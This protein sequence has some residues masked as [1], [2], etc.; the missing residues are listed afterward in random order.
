MSTNDKHGDPLR[1]PAVDYDRSD[2]SARGILLFL[3][4]LLVAG[5]FIELVLWGMFRFLSH[6]TLF[7]QGNPSPM[8]QVQRHAMP[9]KAPGAGLQNTG[10]VNTGVF[11]T[12][13]LQTNDDADMGK[14]L[15]QEKKIL[16]PAQPFEDSSGAIHI[17]INQA[18]ALIA[19]RGLPVRP[20]APAA[21]SSTQAKATKTEEMQKEGVTQKKPA[22][23]Q[24]PA[25]VQQ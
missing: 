4:G 7:A 19:E 21:E 9:E 20:S 23:N 14:F 18:M 6:S 5:I 11:P 17:S 8:V 10:Q 3:A 13:R 1:N 15:S 22:K 16:Y 25:P 2:L 24:A 12:P